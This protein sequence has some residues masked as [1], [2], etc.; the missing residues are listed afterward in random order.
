[1]KVVNVKL[2]TTWPPEDYMQYHFGFHRGLIKMLVP[3]I[4]IDVLFIY[5]KANIRSTLK[6]VD[7]FWHN[8]RKTV[9]KGEY[10]KVKNRVCVTLIST[11]QEGESWMRYLEDLNKAMVEGN[12]HWNFKSLGGL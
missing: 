9:S 11:Y 8:Y 2:E 7:R 1:M 4:G 10:R 5:R 6:Q 3:R 12:S